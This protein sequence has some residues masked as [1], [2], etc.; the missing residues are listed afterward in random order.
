MGKSLRVALLT[1]SAGMIALGASSVQAN[2]TIQDASNSYTAGVSDTGELFDS[3]SYIG[4]RNPAG[5]DYIS[6][7]TPR[8][9]WGFT[10]SNGSATADQFYSSGVTG[11]ISTG[12]TAS[13]ANSATVNTTTNAGLTVNQYF[14]FYA[15]NIVS[16]QHTLTNTNTFDL[17]GVIFR[18]DVDLDVFPSAFSENTVGP[19]GTNGAVVGN[20]YYGFESADPTNPFSFQC[21]ASCNQTGDLGAGIDLGLGTIAAGQSVTFAYYYG[22]N[23]PGQTLSQLFTQAQ[24]LGLSYLIGTQSLENGQWPNQGSGSGFLGVSDIGTIAHGVP[25]PASWAMMLGGFGLVGGALR[26]RRVAVSFA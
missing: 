4:L 11:I 3:N 20:S 21:G 1:A 14:T 5:S 6:P 13:T 15:P 25:E 2:T 24:G 10:S 19:F 8:D 22:I 17:T 16:I 12:I 9:S 23:Q 26:R 18:R 7:G